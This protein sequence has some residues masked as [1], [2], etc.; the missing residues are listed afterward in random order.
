MNRGEKYK[1]GKVYFIIIFIA[2][3]S[4]CFQLTSFSLFEFHRDE[5]LYLSLAGHP[6][7]GYYS[8][9]PLIGLVAFLSIKLFGYTLFAARFFPAIAGGVLIYMGS[10]I[11][12]E[13][14][15]G[16]FAQILTAICIMSSLLFV[17]A[18]GLFQPV[19]FDILF[20]TVSIYFIVKYFNSGNI[21]YLILFGI[22]IGAGL[23]NK[24][25]VLF[26]ISAL[27][28]AIIFTK[29]RIIFTSKYLY[30]SSLAAFIIVLPN[31]IWQIMHGLPVLDHM[32][33]L[34]ST[35]LVN[36][37]PS[38]FLT[39]QF[40]MVI[41][42]TIIVV[43]GLFFVLFSKY[44][45][46]QRILGYYSV[47]VLLIFLVLQGKSYYTAGIYPVLIA[48]GAV[49]SERLLNNA[50][51]RI[52]L[53]SMILLSGLI[54][55][56]M[57]KP[58]LKPDKLVTYFDKAQKITRTDAIRRDEDNNYHKL[59]QDYSDMLG[60]YELTEITAKAWQM[61]EDKEC[62]MI[63]CENYGEAGAIAIIGKKYHLPD[64]VCFNDN[65]R[66]L[67]PKSFNSEITSVIYINDEVGE[68]VADLFSDITEIGKISNPL[69]REYGTEVFLCKNPN[70]S[71]NEF[72]QET[73]NTRYFSK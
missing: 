66:Y 17:R 22:F 63:Y 4:T 2:S 65:F 16:A 50:Y 18:S 28:P 8:V 9:P 59:P 44:L 30:I 35:Q 54:I 45:K 13:I 56:P 27:L 48:C 57:G 23:L 60:W 34:R 67:I 43:P 31:I 25:S 61:V 62:S 58:V 20:W 69:A 6:D 36:M 73:L 53:G 33:E 49:A 12:K 39:E 19:I 3:A 72:W 7:F 10:L 32:S 38:T 24:Y 41:P 26:L 5:L 47:F 40:L 55:L 71:F 29:Q 21:K 1:K 51:S 11:T 46:D 64:P 15:G 70:R 68:D 52:I 42:S 37:S 14:K